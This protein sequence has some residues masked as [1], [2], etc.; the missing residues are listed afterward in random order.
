VEDAEMRAEGLFGKEELEILKNL[1]FNL[2]LQCGKCAAS[3]PMFLRTELNPRTLVRKTLYFTSQLTL[4]PPFSISEINNVWTCTTCN[5][6]IIYC[7]R[8]VKPL[9]IILGLRAILLERGNVPSTIGEALENIYKFGNPFGISSLKRAEWARGLNIK[10]ASRGSKIDLLYFVGCITS[11]D[12]RAQSIARSMVAILKNSEVDFSILGENEN[13]CGNEVYYLG[14]RGLFETIIE[15]NIERFQQY[16]VSK[17][18]A[19]CPHCFNVLKNKYKVGDIE[20]LHHTQLL[21]D[22]IDK[23]MM[24]FSQRLNKKIAFHDPCYLGK[25]NNIFEEPRKILE[26]ILGV[27]LLE[28]EHSRRNSLCCGCGG[29]RMWYKDAGEISRPSEDRVKEAVEIGAEI[30]AVACPL[31]LSELEDAVKKIGYESKLQV[32]DIA[33]VV[34]KSISAS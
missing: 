2:C 7:P 9:N 24:N 5:N 22:L 25:H 4:Y 18:V 12:N 17:I 31:C 34:H 14:E 28:L 26:S 27:T 8:D 15:K 1:N 32:L 10:K 11:Y 23:G 20:I 19:T 6:C 30:L 3:C 33:E 13:C 29:G 16:E 21:S